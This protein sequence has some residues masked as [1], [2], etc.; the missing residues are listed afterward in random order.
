MGTTNVVFSSQRL[1]NV[2]FFP[3]VVKF[4]TFFLIVAFLVLLITLLSCSAK[5]WSYNILTLPGRHLDKSSV[6]TPKLNV[7]MEPLGKP[8]AFP[9]PS[10]ISLR[11]LFAFTAL[12]CSPVHYRINETSCE[13]RAKI[14]RVLSSIRISNP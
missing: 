5:N 9:T 10:S 12:E 4:A 13:V 2:V 7:G 3:S 8:R 1:T 11:T 6:C 14:P